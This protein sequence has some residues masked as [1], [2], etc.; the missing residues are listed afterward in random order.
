M[1][2]SIS[3]L[4]DVRN[5]TVRKR[6]RDEEKRRYSYH[7][8][9]ITAKLGKWH[10]SIVVIDQIIVQ[11]G[12]TKAVYLHCTKCTAYLIHVG[13]KQYSLNEI[14]HVRDKIVSFDSGTQ[15][16]SN[17]LHNTHLVQFLIAFILSVFA[18]S[19]CIKKRK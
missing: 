6:N 14:K 17:F 11:I 19:V 5:I 7:V 10:N 2:E 4:E 8:V 12:N 18:K 13:F 9:S 1:H 16:K 3:S 15:C